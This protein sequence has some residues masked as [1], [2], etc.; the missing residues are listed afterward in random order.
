MQPNISL[1]TINA[2]VI[3]DSDGR[4]LLARYYSP[5]HEYPQHQFANPYPGRKEQR[6]F[7][8]GLFAK[9]HKFDT[10]IILFDNRVVVYKKVADVVIYI[11]GGLNEN[12]SMLYGVVLALREALKLLLEDSV[13]KRTIVDS[14]DLVALAVDE[15]VDDGIILE[16]DPEAIAARVSQLPAYESSVQNLDLSEQGL[17]NAY[18]LAKGKLA[19]RLRQGF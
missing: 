1:Y 2:V 7:E 12:E 9:T 6:T 3:L 4:R 10:D 14:Y 18:Q 8:K 19:E 5:P 13:D 17:M 15:T 16:T 11:V